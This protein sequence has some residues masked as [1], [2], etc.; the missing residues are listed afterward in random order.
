MLVQIVHH[1]TSCNLGYIFLILLITS[2]NVTGTVRSF[3]SNNYF[4]L[5]YFIKYELLSRL[6]SIMYK[7]LF[8]HIMSTQ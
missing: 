1:V 7:S 3:L 8:D 6:L 4:K 5:H 2:S